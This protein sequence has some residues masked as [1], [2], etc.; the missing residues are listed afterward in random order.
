MVLLDIACATLDDAKNAEQGGA[1]SLELSID[2]AAD[3]LTPSLMLVQNVREAVHIPLNVLIRAHARDFVYTHAEKASMLADSRAL[4][5]VCDGFVIGGLLETGAFDV[6]WIRIFAE[7]FPTH[8]LTLHRALDHANNALD[9][10]HSLQGVAQRVLASGSLTTAWNGRETLRAWVQGFGSHY[11]FV[12]AGQVN[13]DNIAAL[14]AETGVQ[15][16]HAARAV[17]RENEVVPNLV[18]SLREKTF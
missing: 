16:C 6:A 17:R 11:S 7:A 8:T 12:A 15:E 1:D 13:Q 9:T 3:G 14:I 2:L 4:A 5:S 18:R 10:L